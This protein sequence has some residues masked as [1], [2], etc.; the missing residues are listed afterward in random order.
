MSSPV[1]CLLC[2]R[3]RHAR[4]PQAAVADKSGQGCL[5]FSCPVWPLWGAA[6][7]VSARVRP[8]RVFGA[9]AACCRSL[10][11]APTGP[12]REAAQLLN[13]FFLC[14]LQ[15]STDHGS[16]LP[17]RPS[18]RYFVASFDDRE[19]VIKQSR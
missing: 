4:P 17:E 15:V 9:T 5:D 1:S 16:H 3:C 14:I 13:F 7:L 11:P 6:M 19:R 2:A 8:L 10:N 18:L 12:A